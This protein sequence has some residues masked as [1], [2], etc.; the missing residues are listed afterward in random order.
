MTSWGRA[1]TAGIC[2]LCGCP[3]WAAVTVEN[4]AQPGAF[5]IRG[6]DAPTSLSMDGVIEKATPSGWVV[7]AQVSLG[8]RCLEDSRPQCR[9]LAPGAVLRPV[10]W[11]GFSCSGQCGIHC[12]QN[13]YLGPGTFRVRVTDCDH[14][15]PVYGPPF[16]L[17]K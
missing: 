6:V 16:Q 3:A 7:V 2:L 11:S 14:A 1:L 4:L 8:E 5:E 9:D 10:R 15:N 12:K 13:I 17:A